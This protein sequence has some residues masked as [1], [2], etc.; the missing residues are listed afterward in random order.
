MSLASISLRAYSKE[1][2]RFASVIERACFATSVIGP[3]AIA[4][5]LLAESKNVEIAF[6]AWST[7]FLANSRTCGGTSIVNFGSIMA[8][9]PGWVGKLITCWKGSVLGDYSRESQCRSRARQG[10]GNETRPAPG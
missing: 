8:H 4:T 7:L 5:D 6:S 1:D 9:P 3:G 2:F 10:K